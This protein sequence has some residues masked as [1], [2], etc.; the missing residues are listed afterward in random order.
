MRT[1]AS[2]RAGSSPSA[3]QLA[4]EHEDC[5]AA[6]E[7]EKRL[8]GV[9]ENMT[10]ALITLDHQGRITYVNRAAEQ[11]SGRPRETLIGRPT[12]EAFAES[13]TPALFREYER[14][15][16][17]RVSVSLEAYY[18]PRASWFEVHV[19]PWSEGLTLLFT[20]V[21]ERK[22]AEAER[23]EALAR[24]Q[25]A[26]SEAEQAS[27]RIV[28]ILE[29][30]TDAFF[31]LDAE[32]RFTYVNRK[33]AEIWGLDR[34]ELIDRSIWEVFP[35]F[36]G[37]EMQQAYREIV[38][39]KTTYA[40][41]FYYPPT[42]AWI[43]L[44]AY[45]VDSG[46][47]VYFEDISERKRADAE[48]ERLLEEVQRRAAELDAVVGSMADGLS[49]LDADG[50]LVRVNE[51]GLNIAGIPPED[52]SRPLQE[53]W[54]RVRPE[55]PD[56]A[57][58]TPTD[59]RVKRALQGE[60]FRGVM[61]ILHP[62]RG[63]EVW[64]SVS[65][66]PIRDPH[67]ETQGVVIT[68]TDITALHELQEQ[69]EDLLRAVSHDLRNPLSA[70]LGQSQ[71]LLRRLEQA[72]LDDQLH[73]GARSIVTS[74]QRMDALIADLVE[75]ARLEAGQIKLEPRPV[76]LQDYA[77]ELKER[78]AATMDVTRI[79][80]EV[81]VDLPSVCA[82][83]AR[84]DRILTNLLSN[85]L[86]YSAPGTPVEVTAQRQGDEVVTS[87]TDHGPGISPEELPRLFQRYFRTRAA[88]EAREGLGLGLFIT[89]RLVEAHGG[90]IWVESEVGTGSTF[91]FSLP[92][93][94]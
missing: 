42:D 28:T 79:R 25:R 88:G 80:A 44:R 15:A 49:I 47:S 22:R 94:A 46:L 20:D 62:P 55:T 35:Q 86:K 6:Q 2:E 72:G 63:G 54:M 13:F 7:A 36:V 65:A 16:I 71:L 82:D 66:A 70:V 59:E 45:P 27:S 91:S 61:A 5:L 23:T 76:R 68:F 52:R 60:A 92:I 24:E 77:S 69:R 78:L 10:D 8:A 29:S 4:A 9:L 34:D 3:G 17:E 75:S 57:P 56:G 81:P 89:R 53:R 1:D 11:F 85:A 26:R 48:R 43:S 50:N 33:A 14:T 41:E 67:G 90:R 84:L 93:A 83:P 87:V 64:V 19:S 51:A 31:A 12:W 39:A 73:S 37:S 30:I 32:A 58:L 74:A 38:A 18:P 21:T 40:I